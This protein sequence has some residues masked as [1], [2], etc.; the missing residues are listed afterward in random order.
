MFP[1]SS[2]LPQHTE[3][4]AHTHVG[5]IDG[6]Y[7]TPYWRILIHPPC[8]N[9]LRYGAFTSFLFGVALPTLPKGERQGPYGGDDASGGVGDDR[10]SYNA[11]ARENSATGTYANTASAS[12]PKSTPLE[13][14]MRDPL[15]AAIFGPRL[16]LGGATEAL[17]LLRKGELFGVASRLAAAAPAE[18]SQ[19]LQDPRPLQDKAL[20]LLRRAEEVAEKLEERGI[21][22]ETPGRELIKPIIP[23]QLFDRYLDPAAVLSQF[24]PQ[25]PGT[26]RATEMETYPSYDAAADDNTAAPASSYTYNA[27]AAADLDPAVAAAAAAVAA[28]LRKDLGGVGSSTASPPLPPPPPVPLTSPPLSPG[29]SMPSTDAASPVPQNLWSAAASAEA[30]AA[31]IV[32]AQSTATATATATREA[33]YQSP[34][35]PF[36]TANIPYP[37]PPPPPTSPPPPPPRSSPPP[38]A[39]AIDAPAPATAV[40]AWA[41]SAKMA[42]RW[43]KEGSRCP[44]EIPLFDAMEMSW[45]FRQA[46]TLLNELTISSGADGWSVASSASFISLKETYPRDGRAASQMRRDLRSGTCEGSL[47]AVE[48]GVHLVLSWRGEL[49]G[50]QDE[51]F[52]LEASGE[53]LKRVVTLTLEN[54]NSWRGTYHYV[55]T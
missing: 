9:P 36:T 48:G 4:T 32:M 35:I 13:R 16:A 18:V 5:H 3:P 50:S 53:T 38:P 6:A 49:A 45:M 8:A 52:T 42:G 28:A 39:A 10:S 2:S 34:T 12:T 33:S 40:D 1:S 26:Y 55:R 27:A 14:I 46:A 43:R 51:V 30:F 7:T 41:A 23:T 22:A 31:D 29:A 25:T 54:G 37:S 24:P 47:E 44:D 11:A 15:S 20:G 17:D 19:L 21:A